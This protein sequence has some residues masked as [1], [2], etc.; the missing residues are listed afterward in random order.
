MNL[1]ALLKDK[2]SKGTSSKMINNLII[3]III[4]V[5][6]LIVYSVFAPSVMNDNSSGDSSPVSTEEEVAV[7]APANY[8]D[9]ME[10]RLEEILTKID[11][12]GKVEVLITYDTSTEVVPAFD[13]TESTQVT[14]EEDKQG[15][16]RTINQETKSSNL[17]TV[18]SSSDNVP[19]VIK[20]IK[21]MIRG[22]I[23][24]AGGA[25][26]PVVR[27]NLIDAVTTIFQIKSHKVKVYSAK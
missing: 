10:T 14:E 22:V 21:P 4:C 19:V 6:A 3:V 9:S 27:A 18:T 26:N 11:G 12:V 7:A 17:V 8:V 1:V 16:I 5:I 24:V 13:T 23:V 25:E 20:E 2:I 15:G